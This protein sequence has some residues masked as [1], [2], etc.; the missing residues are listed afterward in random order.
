[1]NKYWRAPR[2]LVPFVQDLYDFQV[3]DM[4]VELAEF[5]EQYLMEALG[6]D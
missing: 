2:F 4:D 6:K 5:F 1:M 3:T